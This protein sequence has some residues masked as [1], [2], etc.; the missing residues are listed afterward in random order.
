VGLFGHRENDA[1]LATPL[2]PAHPALASVDALLDASLHDL[3]VAVL[4]AGVAPGPAEMERLTSSDVYLR[5]KDA[6]CAA[7]PG[8]DAGSQFDHRSGNVVDEGIQVLENS[9]L[10]RPLR[11]QRLGQESW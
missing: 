2:P 6:V 11:L 7:E 8:P 4:V 5:I 1:P 9:L 3:A 10:L